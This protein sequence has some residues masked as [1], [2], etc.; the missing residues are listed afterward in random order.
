M[1]IFLYGQDKYRLDGGLKDI[2]ENFKSKYKSGLNLS[3]FDLSQGGN[4]SEIENASK[5]LSFFDDKRMIVV[6][7]IFRSKDLSLKLVELIKESK[8]DQEPGVIL[9]MVENQPLKDLEKNKELFK[10]LTNQKNLVREFDYLSGVKLKSWLMSEFKNRKSN[11]DSEALDYL[12]AN[13]GNDSFHLMNELEKLCNYKM[14]ET[15]KLKD[16]ELMTKAKVDLNIFNL[17]DSIAN[18]DKQKAFGLM[19]AQL[20][21]GAN[22]G[23]LLSMIVYQFRNILSIKDLA[24]NKSEASKIAS[25]L[26]MHPFVVQKSIK[27]ARL[28]DWPSLKMIYNHLMLMD[29]NFKKGRTNLGLD[30]DKFILS[31]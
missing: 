17:I 19:Y 24:D 9:T 1:I 11:I 14:G 18:K 22:P 6:K 5:S 20:A 30:L 21:S 8:L 31:L 25:K 2:L 28:F 29:I 27:Q 7:N 13:L 10:I 23:Y 3:Y 12:I 16:V 15:I 26:K 4:L